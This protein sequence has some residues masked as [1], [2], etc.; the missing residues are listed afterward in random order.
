[1]PCASNPSATLSQ[2]VRQGNKVGSWNTTTRDWLTSSQDKSG[3]QRG[4]WVM[5]GDDHGFVRGGRLYCT[6]MAA[7]I[8]EVYYRYMPLYGSGA[9]KDEFSN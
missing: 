8:L 7:M 5:R 9:T 3:H 2:T 4:S 1:M 6:S